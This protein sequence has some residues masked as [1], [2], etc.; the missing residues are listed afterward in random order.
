MKIT[1]NHSKLAKSLQ[2]ASRAVSAKPNI[3]VL[4]NVLLEVSNT[5]LKL[6]AT[7]LDM[8]INMWI[9]GKV[10]EE[11][12]TTVSAKYIAD[13]VAA[14]SSE[15][16]DIATKENTLIVETAKSKA[17]F[18]TIPSNEFPPLPEASNDP[19]FSISA[20]ELIISMEK[21]LFACSTDFS[22]GKIQQTGVLF[23]L[24]DGN[25]D[26]ISF[27]G[28]DGFRLSKRTTKISNLKRDLLS[29]QVIVPARYMSEVVKILQDYPD[30]DTVEVYL[31]ENKSQIIFKFDDVELTLR[32]IE[33]PYPDYKRIMPDS[34]VYTFEVKRSDL[35]EGIKVINTFA[36][37]NLS[38]KTLF[39]FDIE[40]SKVKLK[41]S[42]A[43]VG[44][45]ETEIEVSA[46]DGSGDLNSAY[47]LRFFQDLVSHIK[48]ETIK[49]E[50]KGPLSPS[51]F[52]DKADAK[53]VHILMPLRREV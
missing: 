36:R 9:P 31:S 51:I 21:V 19:I 17:N 20:T 18:S 47:N 27:I 4:S 41:S 50:T 22:A 33:G 11:G 13:F 26:E 7:N 5:D 8:G 12:T 42:V 14:S 15:K 45:N 10:D 37:S 43:E 48:G 1:L 24:E 23:E 32:L 44:E 29:S 28:L 49:F 38:N 6:S 46:T 34:F 16:V 3:P 39:D 30:V 53:Y 52:K 35:E 40:N 25:D 2:Y